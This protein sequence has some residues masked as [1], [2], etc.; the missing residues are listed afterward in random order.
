[1]Q[2]QEAER[3][4]GKEWGGREALNPRGQVFLFIESGGQITS[5]FLKYRALAHQAPSEHKRP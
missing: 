2:G 5:A 3:G 4:T 1:M